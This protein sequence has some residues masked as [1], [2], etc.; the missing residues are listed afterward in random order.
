MQDGS[1]V[2]RFYMAGFY[3]VAARVQFAVSSN[4]STTFQFHLLTKNPL[5]PQ[6][7]TQEV[8][9]HQPLPVQKTR[10]RLHQLLQQ[11]ALPPTKCALPKRLSSELFLLRVARHSPS[12]VLRSPSNMRSI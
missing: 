10:P 11:E 9:P 1:Q 4:G 2:S 6:P 3:G 12:V 5:P 8:L 7:P